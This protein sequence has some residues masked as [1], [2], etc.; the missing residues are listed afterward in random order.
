L[1]NIENV[2]GGSLN[3]L[4]LGNNLNNSLSGGT[5]QDT[6]N[7]GLGVDYLNGGVG[8]DSLVGGDGSDVY[9][10]DAD[11]DLGTDTIVETVTGGVD[12]VDFRNT[13]TKAITL[14]LGVFTNQLVA[15]GVNISLVS[16]SSPLVAS[17]EY[18]YG[19]SFGDNLTGNSLN[20]YFLGGAGNDTLNGGIGSDVLN[21][22][23]GNDSLTGGTGIDQFIYSGAAL[24]GVNTVTALLGRDTITDFGVAVDKISLSKAMF[25]GITSAAGA[26][27][28]NN[29]ASVTTD[30]AAATSAAMIVYSTGTGNLFYNPNGIAAG[31]DA[32]G[33]NFAVLNPLVVGSL[34]PNLAVSDFVV[35]A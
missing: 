28:G 5:G 33:G 10:I 7:G 21:G 13:T 20:N 19:G 2:Y 29:F 8:N 22:G 17:I 27:L 34:K 15:T 11:V 4:I 6:L 32:N 23:V 3:D 25:T 18:V 1:L 35:V 30:G 16:S 12:I 26:S 9:V 24:T 14:N 31:F